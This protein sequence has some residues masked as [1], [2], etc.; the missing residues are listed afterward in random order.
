MA[1]RR[2]IIISVKTSF[3]RFQK[4]DQTSCECSGGKGNLPFSE[5]NQSCAN[6]GCKVLTCSSRTCHQ[7]C[8]NCHMVCTSEVGRCRQRC[9]SGA[10]SFTCNATRCD[11][12][13]KGGKCDG[14]PSS[15]CILNIPKVYLILLAWLFAVVAILSA[16][17]LVVYICDGECCMRQN[18]YSR[19]KTMSSSLE[20][21]DSQP[22][23][24]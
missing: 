3:Q 14:R 10:C 6:T 12:Q 13:C 7:E 18:T 17:L 4:C 21:V 16:L 23:F 9:L 11:Q 15:E 5:C 19:L 2:Q 8:H 24:V 20:S 22:T 1:E